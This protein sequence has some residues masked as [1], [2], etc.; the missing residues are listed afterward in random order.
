MKATPEALEATAGGRTS[1]KR[2]RRE[3]I[4]AA[5]KRLEIKRALQTATTSAPV[6]SNA[7]NAKM[8]RSTWPAST[9][10]DSHSLSPEAK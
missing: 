1:L 3:I 9:Q 2:Q 4:K 6:C 7:K 8:G 10:T 5:P